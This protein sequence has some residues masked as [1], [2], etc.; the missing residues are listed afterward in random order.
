MANIVLVTGAAGALGSVVVRH[1]VAGG[2]RVA[3]IDVPGGAERLAALAKDVGGA[4][5]PVPL[6]VTDAAAWRGALGH[7]EQELGA[8]EG[9]ALIAG[10]FQWTG[11]LHAADDDAWDEMMQTNAGTVERSL[12]ALLPGMV[13]RRRGSVVVIGARPAERPWTGGGMAAYTASKAAVLALA[14]T[15]AAEVLDHGVRVNAVMPST[16]DTPRNRADMPD[17]D[18][19]RWVTPESLA[20][21]IAFLLS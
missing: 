14:Q 13:A 8:P 1:L 9:A 10:G 4:C 3:A 21:V 6:D 11:P 19:S 20:G 5:L 16:F 7:I 17:A 18:F 15:V 2:A 12:R